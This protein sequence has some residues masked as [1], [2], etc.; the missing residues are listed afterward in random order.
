MVKKVNEDIILTNIWL[1]IK[2]DERV[3]K[4]HDD[5][6]V[7]TSDG[8]LSS[9]DI[10]MLKSSSV[11]PSIT[12]KQFMF[13]VRYYINPDSV[14][15][16]LSTTVDNVKYSGI[17]VE[18]VYDKKNT[19]RKILNSSGEVLRRLWRE[20]IHTIDSNKSIKDIY[21]DRSISTQNI[22]KLNIVSK[23]SELTMKALIF[24]ITILYKPS[25]NVLT[26]TMLKDSK[27]KVYSTG[28]R[29]EINTG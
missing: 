26:V 7:N 1:Q 16:S 13:L 15:L 14:L 20:C 21:T 18:Y 25:M 3:D 28:F 6:I 10:K 17:E 19:D 27:K 12:L 2:K 11:S 8:E 9:D 22:K 24:A 5:I 23:N 4:R 29:F